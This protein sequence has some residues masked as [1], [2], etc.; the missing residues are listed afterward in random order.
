MD[1]VGPLPLSVGQ[2]YLLTCVVRL[3]HWPV[4]IS[5]SDITAE[6]VVNTFLLHW[7]AGCEVPR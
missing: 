6:T 2:R 5:I 7:V 3:T 1:L 4:A